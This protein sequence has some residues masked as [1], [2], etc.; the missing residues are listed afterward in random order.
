TTYTWRASG[1]RASTAWAPRPTSTIRPC[2]AASAIT[3]SVSFTIVA[4]SCSTGGAAAEARNISGEATARAPASRSTS[5]GARSSRCATSAGGSPARSATWSTNSLSI[6]VQPSAPATRRATSDPPEAYCR[7]M[8]MT[9]A[10]M[11]SGLQVLPQVSDV[12]QRQTALGGHEDDQVVRA[13]QVVQHFDPLLGERFGR[14]CLVQQPLLLGL[15]ARDFDAVPLG[16]DL[17][18]LGDLVVDRLHHLLR[19]LEVAQKERRDGG[20]AEL[21]AARAGRGDERRV[22]QPF[23]GRGDLRAFG[24][25]VDRELHDPVA[26]PLADRVEHRPADLV[27]VADLGEDLRG[28]HRVDLPTDRHLDVH[29]HLLARQGLDR[30]GLLA[31]RGPLLLAGGVA[32]DRRPGRH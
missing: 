24:D 6:T 11:G 5:P 16:L 19:R 7:V 31:A 32:L 29:P 1:R 27:F 25:V 13:L 21:A 17:L 22:D 8:V 18:L 2:A 30:F 3:R 12:E 10:A 28:L 20:D 4:S 14:E 9:G 15:E 23:H 26:D